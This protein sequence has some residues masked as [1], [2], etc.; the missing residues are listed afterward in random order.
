VT[1]GLGILFVLFAYESA[2]PTTWRAKALHYFLFAVL[3][4]L[5]APVFLDLTLITLLFAAMPILLWFSLSASGAI[6]AG[7]L[8]YGLKRL[9][10]Q[11]RPA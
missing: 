5:I 2:P 6:A 3:G 9:D 8:F 1:S 4:L 7:S 10:A 11:S